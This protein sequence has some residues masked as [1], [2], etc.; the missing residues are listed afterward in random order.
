MMSPF[1]LRTEQDIQAICSRKTKCNEK[2]NS[3]TRE[4]MTKGS[5]SLTFKL[6]GGWR[7]LEPIGSDRH[8]VE[9]QMLWWREVAV[10]TFKYSTNILIG[11]TSHRA[12][13]V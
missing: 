12:R 8:D 4:T 5:V 13:H 3:S 10:E 6:V 7:E 9:S 1:L 11:E 2:G